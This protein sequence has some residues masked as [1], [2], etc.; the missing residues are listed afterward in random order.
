MEKIELENSMDVAAKR[1]SGGYSSFQLIRIL[2]AST[3]WAFLMT[4]TSSTLRL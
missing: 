3:G 4:K 1:R 2:S